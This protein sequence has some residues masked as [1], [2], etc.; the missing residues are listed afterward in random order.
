MG[1]RSQQS[2]IFIKHF[3][4]VTLP[5]GDL[6]AICKY[7]SKAYKWQHGGG[8]GTLIR[9]IEKNHP[10]E[11]GISR[12]QS[13]IPTF[14]SQ[15]GKESQLFKFSE[16]DFRDET[17]RFVAVEQLSF[18]FGDK[19]S[20]QNWLSSSANPAIRRIPRNTLKRTIHKLVATQK[21]E[22]IKE[23]AS[24]DNK[25]TLCSDIWSDHWQSCSYM[26]IICHWIDNAWNIQKRLLAYRCFNDP[27][28]AQNISH[29]MFLILEEYGLTSKIFSISFD[30]ASAN[31]CSIDELIRM[32][33]PSIG[34]KFFHIRCTCHIL[35]LCVQDGFRSLETYIKPIR[36]AIH[37]PWTHPQVMKQWGRFCKAN[38]MRAKRFARDVPTRWNSTYKLLLSTFEYKE[39]LCGFFGQVVQSSSLYLFSNQWNICT[40]ICEIRQSGPR[41]DSGLLRQTALEVLTRSARSDSPRRV[42]RKRISGDNGAAA[43]AAQ[44]GGGGGVEEEERGG[45]A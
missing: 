40:I 39:L 11:I 8:Y 37:Y 16:S 30:N 36:T 1:G 21:N 17:A 3:D 28:T 18:S 14:S 10:V 24:L 9:H 32:C 25:V 27:H 38:G 35:N 43:A 41:P 7:C 6:Q 2:A 45:F 42:G 29:L 12:S 15:S 34:G 31:T 44:G 13:Q 26:G 22:L 19:L 5:S 4:K 23:F 20:F 33:Q